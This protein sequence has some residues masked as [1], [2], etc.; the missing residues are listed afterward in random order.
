MGSEFVLK[1]SFFWLSGLPGARTHTSASLCVCESA[2]TAST[3]LQGFPPWPLPFNP[4]GPAQVLLSPL[5]ARGI[6]PAC[7]LCPRAPLAACCC[8]SHG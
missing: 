7:K 6:A 3:A 2:F 4:E 8:L 5:A 1:G